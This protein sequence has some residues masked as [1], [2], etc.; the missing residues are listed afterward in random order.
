MSLKEYVKKRNFKK[1]SEPKNS[2]ISTKKIKRFAVQH[3]FTKR[4]HFDLRLEYGK[5]LISF[6]IP[7]GISCK[8]G[9]KRLAVHVEDHPLDY[10]FF[11]GEIPSGEYGAGKVELFDHGKYIALKPIR[12]SM[13][14]GTLKIAFYGNK[15]KGI[16]NMVQ[17]DEKNW[18][19]IKGS[20]N[21]KI[22]TKQA[23]NN[24]KQ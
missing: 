6:A 13:K 24:K 2:K 5:V 7:K 15:I 1:T 23:K 20:E 12:N 21:D 4:E 8:V 18:L 11:E 14:N 19:I 22:A 3:H 17:I 9:E 10:I 16:Y